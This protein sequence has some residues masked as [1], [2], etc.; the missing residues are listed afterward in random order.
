MKKSISE[1]ENEIAK[2]E[3]DIK[4]VCDEKFR[5][6]VEAYRKENERCFSELEEKIGR[7][8]MKIVPEIFM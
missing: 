7:T 4:K 1:A 8:A 5:T 3:I 2:R 6:E